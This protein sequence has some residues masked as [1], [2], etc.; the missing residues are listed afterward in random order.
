MRLA[1]VGDGP[2]LGELRTLA[3]TLGIS[4][5]TWLPGAVHNVPEVLRAFDLFVLPSLNE[6]ISNTTLEALASGV[7]VVATRVGGNP[8]LVDDGVTGRLMPA[9][10]VA[11][12]ARAIDEYVND[13]DMR[14]QHGATARR[15]AVERFSLTTMVERYQAVYDRLLGGAR[16][17]T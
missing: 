14:R 3:T 1:V 7:P 17:R 13:A 11:A 15:V 16:P 4:A 12:L 2:L 8:E 10:D 6:G 9:G 5:E